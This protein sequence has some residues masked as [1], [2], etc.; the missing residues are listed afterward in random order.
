MQGN[1]I[2]TSATFTVNI[3]NHDRAVAAQQVRGRGEWSLH[4]SGPHHRPHLSSLPQP[5]FRLP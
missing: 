2:L 1:S 5:V 3:A 4:L